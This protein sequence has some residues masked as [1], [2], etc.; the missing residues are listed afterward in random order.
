MQEPVTLPAKLPFLLLLGAEGIAVGMA[1]KILPHNFCELLE[2]QKCIL[3]NEDFEILPDFPKGGILDVS[4]YNHGNGKIKCRARIEEKNEKTIVITEIPHSTTTQSL[5]DS[6]EKAARGGKLKILSIDDYTA[7]EVEIEIKLPRSIYANDTIRALYA[8][9]DCEVPISP[10]LTVIVNDAP[11]ILDV[12]DVL[13][14]NTEKLL[15]DLEK[16]LKIELDRLHE[17]LQALLL[18]QIFIEER[19]YKNIEECTSYPQVTK[20]VADGIAPFADR[21]LRPVTEEDIERLLEIRI[22]RISRYDIDKKAKDVKEVQLKVKKVRN[23][24]KDM[25]K[26]TINYL[27]DLLVKYG[28]DFPRRTEITT[29]TEVVARKVAISNLTCGYDPQTGFLG[30]HVKADPENTFACSEYD[31]FILIAKDGHYKVING[32]DKLFVGQEMM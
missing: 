12:E 21:L 4:G 1:T 11:A 18:E 9:T 3:R 27:D 24:L 28:K 5:V 15:Q 2:A 19:I 32:T 25:V 22:K 13:R 6:I 29:F 31:K 30:Y 17:K 26:F 7:E 23:D 20:T 16:E 10:N 8:F 14:F